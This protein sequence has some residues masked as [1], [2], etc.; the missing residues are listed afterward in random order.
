[1]SNKHRKT[2]EHRRRPHAH[3]KKKRTADGLEA[4]MDGPGPRVTPFLSFLSSLDRSYTGLDVGNQSTTEGE[5][6]WELLWGEE[7]RL[8]EEASFLWAISRSSER[9]RF[10]TRALVSIKRAIHCTKQCYRGR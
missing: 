8:S 7:V 5:N 10:C 4:W 9:I 3:I 1:M 6:S 2:K